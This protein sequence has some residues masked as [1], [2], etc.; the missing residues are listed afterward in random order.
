MP[1]ILGREGGSALVKS[2]RDKASN[3]AYPELGCSNGVV[4]EVRGVV[5]E[6]WVRCERFLYFNPFFIQYSK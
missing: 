5:A 2:K 1:A 6:L 3:V 4:D